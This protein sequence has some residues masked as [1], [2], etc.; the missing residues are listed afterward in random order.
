LALVVIGSIAYAGRPEAFE[1]TYPPPAA[2]VAP[3]ELDAFGADQ[4]GPLTAA[5]EK[6][7]IAAL[8]AADWPPLDPSMESVIKDRVAIAP[9]LRPCSGVHWPD[10]QACTW[11]APT[12]PLRVVLVGNSVAV[13]Y[14]GPLRE[15]ALNSGGQ[16]QL[17]SSAMAG[18]TFV[19]EL[20][21]TGD[22]YYLEA[23]PGRKQQAIDFINATKP[24]VVIISNTY[25]QKQIHGTDHE[26]TF[27]EFSDSMRRI[28]DTFR[29]STDKI[30]FLAPPPGDLSIGDCYGT[31]SSTPPDCISGVGSY[32]SEM[33]KVEQDL[34]ASTAATWIDSRPWFCTSMCPSFV[35]STPTKFD[36]AHMVPAYGLKIAPV[37]DESFR[38]AGVFPTR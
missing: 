1:N 16:I 38:Q 19:S 36:V 21:T 31:R 23:C 12:A 18:C 33:A 37:I 2:A 17:F 13:G 35:G 27:R 11:G 8:Q 14:M 5:L 30:V 22:P 25:A 6:E 3:Q 15:I 29:A 10:P 4:T 26:M 34:A 20:I 9:E 24:D 7:I 28:I 32:W